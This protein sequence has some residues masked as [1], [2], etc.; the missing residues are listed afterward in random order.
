M[1]KKKKIK[2]KEKLKRV[3]LESQGIE[4]T[5]DQKNAAKIFDDWFTDKGYHKKPIL[6]IGG[7]GG[8]GK[9][10]L[11]QYLCE[12]YGFDETNALFVSYTGQS[13]NRLIQLGIPA[14]TIHS[15]FMHATEVPLRNKKGEPILKNG[16]PVLITKWC[17]VDHISSRVKII[18]GD[19]WSFV[20][21][22]LE[23]TILS[24]NTPV[25]V[26]GD[27]LQLPP[28][29]GKPTFSMD[30]LDYM[31]TQIMRQNLDSEIIDLSLRIRNGEMPPMNTYGKEVRLL[32]PQKD[33]YETFFRFK[34]FFQFSDVIITTTNKERQIITDLYRSEIAHLDTAL[35][36]AGEPLICRRNNWSLKLGPYPLTNGMMG[37]CLRDVKRSEV[38]F[39]QKV[40][41]IDFQPDIIANEYF[42]TLQCDLEYFHAPFG[43]KPEFNLGKD[44]NTGNK[45]EFAYVL[46]VHLVQG[47][48]RDRVLYLDRRVGNDD[49][50]LRMRY[51][52]V[53]R[54]RKRLTYILPH[55]W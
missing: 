7:F 8:T 15:T 27:P 33:I 28:V 53:T 17:P 38:N 55:W 5:N 21:Q 32:Y 12:K 49:Y 14:K 40:F 37:K 11:I 35:P 34:S 9:G 10:I 46:T 1:A 43:D 24:Y 31:L 2:T 30:T 51:T 47:D 42:D 18:I 41:T 20:P 39:K 48:Q 13:V 23:E 50:M 52:A 3:T 29:T 6:R 45:L 22:D 16:I 36:S 26:F 25:V 54:A 4:L 44:Y 19:E